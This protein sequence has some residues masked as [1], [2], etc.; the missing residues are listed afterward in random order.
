[1]ILELGDVIDLCKIHRNG[2]HWAV[3]FDGQTVTLTAG[4]MQLRVMD[5]KDRFVQN[6]EYKIVLSPEDRVELFKRSDIDLRLK[7]E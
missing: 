7:R 2:S 4:T 6:S 1:M 5:A 3:L